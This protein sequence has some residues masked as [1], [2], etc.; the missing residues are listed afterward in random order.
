[1]LF[2]TCVCVCRCR[3][4]CSLSVCVSVCDLLIFFQ[5]AESKAEVS[6]TRLGLTQRCV[7]YSIHTEGQ[8]GHLILF[9]NRAIVLHQGGQCRWA[10][11]MKG[12]LIRAQKPRSETISCIQYLVKAK[13]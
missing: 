12:W 11:G 8:K 10:G 6:R 2:L 9:N 13:P 7:V 1:V 3:G 4:C 5:Q